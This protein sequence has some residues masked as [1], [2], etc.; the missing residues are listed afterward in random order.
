[1]GAVMSENAV[2][3]LSW[4]I[5]GGVVAVLL[6][7]FFNTTYSMAERGVEKSNKNSEEIVRLQE[8]YLNTQAKVS[9][10]LTTQKEHKAMSYQNNIDIQKILQILNKK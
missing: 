2:T 7:M 10:I 4:V 9:E 3:K 6:G 8:C 5:I 1:M